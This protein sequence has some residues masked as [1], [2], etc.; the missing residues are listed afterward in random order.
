MNS[1]QIWM[2]T[3]DMERLS[4]LIEGVKAAESKKKPYLKQLEQELDRAKMVDPK[5]IPGDV[6]TMNSVVR[7]RDLESGEAMQYS[8]VFPSDAR[9]EEG[10][11]SILSALGTALIGYRVG[12]AI[13]W[14]MPSGLKHW[15]VE[16]I[17]YQPEASG[18]YD[19]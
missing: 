8:L 18:H 11:I 2:T 9:I 12:D 7:I 1:R 19:R 4:R 17:L 6:I 14:E 10:R 3:H 13:E 16:E 5:S 15:K